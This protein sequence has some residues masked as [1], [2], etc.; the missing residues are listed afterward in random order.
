MNGANSAT[1]AGAADVRSP[2]PRPLDGVRVIEHAQNGAAPFAG[3]ILSDL[4][5]DVIKVEPPGGDRARR[6]GVAAPAFSGLFQ[7]ANAG[8]RSISIDCDTAGGRTVMAALL[9]RADCVLLD[10]TSAVLAV[11]EL[12]GR[13]PGRAVVVTITPFGLDCRQPRP[14]TGARALFHAGGEGFLTPNGAPLTTPPVAPSANVAWLD[15][16]V[17][18]AFAA[19]LVL[20]RRGHGDEG[21]FEAPYFFDLAMRD[22]QL[23]LSRQ[24]ICTFAN[25]G[26]LEDRSTKHS[27]SLGPRLRCRD[28]D[29]TIHLAERHWSGWCTLM[30]RDDLVADPRFVTHEARMANLDAVV[31]ELERWTMPRTRAEVQGLGQPRGLPVV[32]I[33]TPS[34][35]LAD[36]QL[37]YRGFFRSPVGSGG[38]LLTA[39]LPF[40]RQDG[41]RWHPSNLAPPVGQHTGEVL[42]EL[43]QHLAGIT[44]ATT[45][46]VV[47]SGL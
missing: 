43:G 25:E 26:H 32:A 8:K 16:G 40:V 41:Q 38:P 1:S 17:A 31:T 3:R 23:S 35:V 42:A 2:L 33:L 44:P 22:V 24:D 47:G 11:D 27:A 45:A 10:E 21:E 46:G 15:A 14:A 29:A 7:H 28:G 39:A 30:D 18:G 36:D 19:M 6:Q 4:G 5:A 20:F 9:E 12:I 13:V 34:E 37:A